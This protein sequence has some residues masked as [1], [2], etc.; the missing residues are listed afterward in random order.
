MNLRKFFSNRVFKLFVACLF[1]GLGTSVLL[2]NPINSAISDMISGITIP[3][4]K[5]S[6]KI[7]NAAEEVSKKKKTTEE[8][9]QEIKELKDE[10]QKLRAVTVDYFNIKKENTQYLKFYEIKKQ[11]DSLKFIPSS[12]VV[13][14]PNDNFYG[15]TLDKGKSSG[16]NVN[17]PVMTENGI[18]GW[19]SAVGENYC[20]VKTIL[21]PETKIGVLCKNSL[22]TGVITGDVKLSDQ[23]L[24]KMVFLSA[25]NKLATDDIIVTSGLGGI[26]PKDIPIGKVKSIIADDYDYSFYA[27]IEPYDDIRALYNVFIVTDFEG[28]GDISIETIVPMEGNKNGT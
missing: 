17:N 7:S 23:N 25:Q 8:Y 2:I 10:N 24:T 9:E 20:K 26:Y 6:N 12:V 18:V 16:V 22:D 15:F 13:R 14:D 5:I 19:V 28:K 1:L 4:Q 21:S 27:Q 11:N 3:M